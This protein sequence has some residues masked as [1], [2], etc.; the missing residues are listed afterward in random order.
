MTPLGIQSYIFFPNIAHGWTT[1]GCTACYG[2]RGGA[3][4]HATVSVRRLRNWIG[5]Y[6]P[7]TLFKSLNC[8]CVS[9]ALCHL[10][11][12]PKS[13]ET[14]EACKGGMSAHSR[15][16]SI[17]QMSPTPGATPPN[18]IMPQS[19]HHY[20]HPSDLSE[21]VVLLFHTTTFFFIV[22]EK[23]ISVLVS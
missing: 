2:G 11:S 13:K 16:N 15:G 22:D 1:T 20:Y 6:F 4:L 9:M 21:A 3:V 10:F 19:L 14:K 12:C 8:Q 23:H 7:L 17:W 5:K 18:V